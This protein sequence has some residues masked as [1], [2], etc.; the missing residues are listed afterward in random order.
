MDTPGQP[1]TRSPRFVDG[2]LRAA[3]MAVAF[4]AAAATSAGCRSG[5]S[6][7]SAP[8][9]WSFGGKGGDAEKLSAAPPFEGSIKK[10]SELATPYP[11]TTTPNAYAVADATGGSGQPVAPPALPPPAEPAT[12][13]YGSQPSPSTTAASMPTAV[14][15]PPAPP[16][17]APQVGP[18]APLAG[19]APPAVP[20]AAAPA[21]P[22]MAAAPAAAPPVSPGSFPATAG[23][24]PTTAAST[25]DPYGLAA[26][27]ALPA[28]VEPAAPASRY[29]S[30]P[31]SRFGGTS[32]SGPPSAAPLEP[33]ATLAPPVSP[34]PPPTAG[35]L[36]AAPPLPSSAPLPSP[37][38]LPGAPPLPSPPASPLPRRPDPGYRPGGTSSYRPTR[39]ILVESAPA[40]ASAVRTA[41][42]ETPVPAAD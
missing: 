8:S 7:T 39:A 31:G 38:V 16:P 30:V 28:P 20:P 6:A 21:Q 24:E 33:V 5:A 32:F 40:A 18:Y 41:A 37:P 27:P 42:F 17:I 13:T 35:S 11:T 23:Y 25:P 12:I 14:T 34:P 4:V 36:P 26:T 29:A 22:A 9:W 3:L 19:A 1:T 2:R 15:A 10:P